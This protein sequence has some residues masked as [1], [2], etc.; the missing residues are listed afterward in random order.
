MEIVVDR[1]RMPP[2][3]AVRRCHRCDN[4]KLHETT[5]FCCPTR[6]KLGETPLLR[7]AV[8]LGALT[9]VRRALRLAA[10]LCWARMAEVEVVESILAVGRDQAL[11]GGRVRLSWAGRRGWTTRF[12]QVPRGFAERLSRYLCIPKHRRARQLRVLGGCYAAF[13]S[14]FQLAICLSAL[15]DLLE[16]AD[17]QLP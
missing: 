15:L 9:A 2:P 11:S 17:R 14:S 6:A 3:A 1:R 16:S 13:R 12:Q 4:P 7:G 8:P 10:G 5:L